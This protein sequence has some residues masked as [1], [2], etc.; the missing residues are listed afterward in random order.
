MLLQSNSYVVP[1]EKRADHAKLVRRMRQTMARLGCDQF[2]VFEQVPPNWGTGES[3]GR[4]V[5]MMKFRDRR[6]QQAVQS[7]EQRDPSAQQLIA[8]FCEL[9]NFPYQQQQGLFAA[10]FYQSVLPVAPPVRGVEVEFEHIEGEGN[11]APDAG[12][13]IVEQPPEPANEEP[14]PEPPD[15]DADVRSDPSQQR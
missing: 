1:K 2:D 3:T 14:E 13:R 5:Q 10:G 8:E 15:E 7:A 4:F 12:L 6:H 11:S 9:I